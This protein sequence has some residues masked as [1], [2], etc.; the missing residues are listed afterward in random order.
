M[1]I[2]GLYTLTIFTPDDVRCFVTCRFKS[3]ALIFI[4][5]LWEGKVESQGAQG[6]KQ[7]GAWRVLLFY[8]HVCTFTILFWCHLPPPFWLCTQLFFF[9]PWMPHCFFSMHVYGHWKKLY[10]K[11]KD[12]YSMCF[13]LAILLYLICTLQCSL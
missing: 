6:D 8:H 7:N 5:F 13:A 9:T 11:V 10:E 3:A 4:V 2:A 1:T 12:R